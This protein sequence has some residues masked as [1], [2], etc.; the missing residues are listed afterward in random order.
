MNSGS[1]FGIYLSGNFDNQQ[2]VCTD[3]NTFTAEWFKLKTL[4]QFPLIQGCNNLT[5]LISLIYT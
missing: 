5:D 2:V 3:M 4:M 1:G